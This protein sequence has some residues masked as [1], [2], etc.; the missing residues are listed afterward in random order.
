MKFTSFTI[1]GL[2]LIEPKVFG[3]ERGFF[4][5]TF[6]ASIFEKRNIPTF[7]PQDNHSRSAKGVLRGLHF[8]VP[9]YHQGK[10]LRVTAGRV[11]DVAVDIRKGS[12]HYGKWQGAEISATNKNMFW[13]PPGF[14]HG[15]IVLDDNTDFLYKVTSEYS[16]EHELGIAY[17]D[18]Q[19]QIPWQEI[20]GD[21][22]LIISERDKQLPDL[23]DID[24]PF[25]F[26][27]EK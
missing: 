4:M 21:L 3:D 1:P 19:I 13:V 20:A 24:S 8:Q 15:F 6:K 17:D 11:Y 7:Y 22:P 2:L 25:D 14:A 12:P 16:P 9:P 23:A 18:K 5:E 10:L 26:K 27:E